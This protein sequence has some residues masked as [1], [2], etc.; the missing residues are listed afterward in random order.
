MPRGWVG[1][2]AFLFGQAKEVLPQE[3]TAYRRVGLVQEA[4]PLDLTEQEG[5]L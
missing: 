3:P 1:W 5:M 2:G 4:A